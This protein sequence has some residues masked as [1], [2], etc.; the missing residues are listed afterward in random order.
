MGLDQRV[1]ALISVGVSVGV[2]CQP[3][4][5]HCVTQAKALGIGEQEIREAIQVGRVVHRGA[6]NRMDQ[7]MAALLAGEKAACNSQGC[8][9][10][11][12]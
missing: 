1:K 5:E 12:S 9:C 6:A 8:G 7:Y 2:N 10:G 11:C 3:C 4:L